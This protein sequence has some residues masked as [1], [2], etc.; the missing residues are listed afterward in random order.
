MPVGVFVLT[1]AY[2][3]VRYISYLGYYTQQMEWS[4]GRYSM[5]RFLII[6]DD[7]IFLS[8]E[9]TE[10]KMPT[11]ERR[12]LDTPAM[13]RATY[14]EE[15]SD[16][17][18]LSYCIKLSDIEL[19]EL[20]FLYKTPTYN[21]DCNI[22]H[23]ACFVKDRAQLDNS[24]LTG[25]WY[26]LHQIQRLNRVRGIAP[27]LTAEIHRI[28]T[29]AM[30]WKTY[31]KDGYR[32]YDIRHYKPTFRLRD[33]HRWDVDINDTAWLTVAGN[34]EDVPFFRLRRLWRRYVNGINS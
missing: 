21:V 14:R 16:A 25:N 18:A 33:L 9:S 34:N 30:A 20:R 10:Y 22:Y 26:T 29:V 15:I 4:H 24:Q 2:F 3:T 6:C 5:I 27:I 28:Y 11:A 31:D 12:R 17:V 32:L 1:I 23:Y 19:G 7:Y 13:V 8:E